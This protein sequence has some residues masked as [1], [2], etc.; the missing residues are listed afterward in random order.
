MTTSDDSDDT[1]ASGSTQAEE[2]A[3]S[4]AAEV[5]QPFE[6]SPLRVEEEHR[7]PRFL[8]MRFNWRD[9]DEMHVLRNAHAA[10]EQRILQEFHDAFV[11]LAE[12]QDIVRIQMKAADGEPLVDATGAPVWQHTPGGRIVEDYTRLTRQQMESFLGQI[13]TRLFAWEQASERMW[14]DCMMAKGQFEERYAVSY[15]ALR[16]SASR[17]TVDDRQQYAA[18]DASEERYF[19]IY[20]TSASRRAQAVV[21]SMER[22]G[23]RLKDVLTS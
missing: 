18:M 22:L 5:T 11:I 7:S 14:M 10:V 19:T 13:T 4:A 2:D 23:Q 21:R 15:D 12:I 6:P 17:T 16:G 3:H 8:R 9:A 1:R 20:L